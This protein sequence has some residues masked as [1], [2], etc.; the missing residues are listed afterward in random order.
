[1][2]EKKADAAGAAPGKKKESKDAK[3]ADSKNQAK[4]G[5]GDLE[6]EMS[7]EDRLLQEELALL[8]SRAMDTDAGVQKLALERIRAEIRSATSSMTSVPKPLKFMRD[9]YHPL[10][11]FHESMMDEQN[12]VFLS[13][14]LSVL[15]M[16]MAKEGS[17][18]SLRFKLQGSG[19]PPQS[20]GHEYVRSLCGEIGQE[21]AVRVQEIADAAAE[22]QDEELEKMDEQA[23]IDAATTD[24]TKLVREI[25]PFLLASNAQS[26]AV[27][28][29]MEVDNV[30]LLREYVTEAHVERVAM[31]LVTCASYLPEPDDA[32]AFHEAAVLYKMCNQPRQAVRVALRLR[33]KHMIKEIFRSADAI[34]RKQ[35]AFDLSRHNM[36]L[37]DDD[38]DDIDDM[39][40]L[41][42]DIMGNVKLSEHFL[43]LAKDL[44]V[45]EPKLPAD[46]YKSHLVDNVRAGAGGT[47]LSSQSNVDSAR[48]NLA[49]TFVNAFVNC[50][51]GQDKL[52]SDEENKWIYRNK[53]HGMMSAT[54]SLG[55]IMQWDL[56]GGLGKID[57]YMY[58]L[59]DHVKAGALLAV[60]VLSAGCVRNECDPALALLS[61]H[62]DA[63][64]PFM[65]IGAML[66]LGIAYAGTNRE[67]IMELLVPVVA[68]G[69][70]SGELC[71]F[72]A[73]A[74]GLVFVGSANEDLAAT[75]LQVLAERSEATDSS[76]LLNDPLLLSFLPVS[77]GFV[78]LGRQEACE[79]VV[80]SIQAMVHGSVLQKLCATALEAC[81]YACSG[82]VLKVQK[83]LAMC[84]E[85]PQEQ[86]DDVAEGS[87][88]VSV[89]AGAELSTR[90][91]AGGDLDE[92]TIATVARLGA[93]SMEDGADIDIGS[94]YAATG[95]GTGGGVVEGS[96]ESSSARAPSRG[97]T[98]MAA[99]SSSSGVDAS[100]STTADQGEEDMTKYAAALAMQESMAVMGIAMVAMQE[101]TG[102]AMA[103]RMCSHLL[104]YGSP[105]VRRT[106]PLM[107]GLLLISNPQITA[108]EALSK[109]TH[110][111]DTDVAQLA[112][113]ALG[114]I[115]AGTNHSR[116]AGMLR[117]LS[118]YYAKDA[119]PLF[120][121]RIAQ[122]LLHA[123]KGLV[124]FN[125]VHSGRFLVN[126][127]ALAGLLTVLCACFNL[128]GTILGK[129]HYILYV[130]SLTMKPRM[131]L[132]VD[133]E[134]LEPL[135]V[136]VRVGTAVD[137]VGLVGRPKTITGFQTHAS[138]VVLAAGER[139]EIGTEE[140]IASCSGVLENV[141]L[142]KKNP[143]YIELEK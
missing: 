119:G 10:K 16:S 75:L 80:E 62:I 22:K 107:Y 17:R 92:Q 27:D 11:A 71:A 54:A 108:M 118:S 86:A 129:H 58:S 73:L 6:V 95:A 42:K 14:I 56:D 125:P 60:G 33:D 88:S 23:A 52:L 44:E 130:L 117:Q 132:C 51:F 104:Q 69:T 84:G 101:E 89:P 25:V 18:E 134:T 26:E 57:K 94:S 45:L 105:A 138:P 13:D 123:A 31:Y 41:L 120:I 36:V 78:F 1:M 106:I 135:D 100:A 7:E 19:D 112:I 81:A 20:W 53:E 55:M 137:T 114:L 97:S 4:K 124:T 8:A 76:G 50:G 136:P 28:L 32:E 91:S 133:E 99:E 12:K 103:L 85:R 70:V 64:V 49:S 142:L 79:A 38:G 83:F 37:D 74:L 67:D 43:T 140:Y 29:L 116:I 34:T 127:V 87:G 9:H 24:L 126:P 111:A 93:T 121:T 115:G 35:L 82:N 77:L 21:Y 46:I 63:S 102:S 3:G 66:G 2:V 5:T 143:E 40:E 109:L 59:E 39:D 113:L 47:G 65:K 15:A 61:E 128:K 48:Q 141:V 139:A 72:A 122:G 98:S 96:A 68:D 30:P 110:D 131:L 90:E